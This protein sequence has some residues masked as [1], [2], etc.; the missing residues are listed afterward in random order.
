M[1][2]QNSSFFASFVF[3]LVYSVNSFE[4]ESLFNN[5][6]TSIF[7][8]EVRISFEFLSRVS[9]HHRRTISITVLFRPNDDH[10]WLSSS[11][12]IVP[13]TWPL[14]PLPPHFF[15]LFLSA[16]SFRNHQRL[17]FPLSPSLPIVVGTGRRS[18]DIRF[19]GVG[20]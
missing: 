5:K 13:S 2:L 8:I 1:F 10:G 19:N 14:P 15:F 3:R 20:R 7:V 16:F 9:L 12:I 17:P 4:L 11:L 18:F 6:D